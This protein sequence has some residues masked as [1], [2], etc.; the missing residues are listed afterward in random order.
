MPVEFTYVPTS[1]PEHLPRYP[2]TS[3]NHYADIAGLEPVFRNLVIDGPAGILTNM[4]V[5]AETARATTSLGLLLTHWTGVLHPVEAA[6]QI[7]RLDNLSDGRLS[8]RFLLGPDGRVAEAEQDRNLCEALQQTDEYLVL[9]KRLWSNDQ[10]FDHEGPD[11]SIRSGLVETKGSQ[12]ADIGIRMSGASG[13]AIEIAARHA[14]VFELPAGSHAETRFLMQR[15]ER[16]AA[17][18]GRQGRIRFAMP[19]YWNAFGYG[20]THSSAALSDGAARALLAFAALGIDE[21]MLSGLEGADVASRFASEVSALFTRTVP[22]SAR[23]R[24]APLRQPAAFVP[25]RRR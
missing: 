13:S 5:A 8:L 4:D 15:L 3:G 16:A 17:R 19:V 7:A 6:A 1:G 14:T 18:Y 20:D 22:L 24:N 2:G 21:F 11:Y 25:S 9:L 23:R 10:P 12:G